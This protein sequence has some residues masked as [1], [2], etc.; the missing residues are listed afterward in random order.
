MRWCTG[1]VGRDVAPQV[2]CDDVVWK[3]KTRHTTFNTYQRAARVS[4][5]HVDRFSTTV[6]DWCEL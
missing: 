1:R 3:I 2:A 5:K 6:A 4:T